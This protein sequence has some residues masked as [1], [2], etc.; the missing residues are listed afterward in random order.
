MRASLVTLALL[1]AAFPAH[2]Q[3]ARGD[4]AAVA[5]AARRA[6][7]RFE[8]VRR[9]S[10]PHHERRA[11]ECDTR[12][13]VQCYWYDS[14]DRPPTP[15]EH[16]RVTAARR[17]LLATLDSLALRSTRD[18]GIFG[19]RV[20]YHLEAG[21]T[22]RAIGIAGSE[23][24]GE[25]WWCMAL[26]GYVH[27][28]SGRFAAA[29]IAFDSAL[30]AMDAR[31]RCEWT[32]ASI[33]LPDGARRILHRLPC[34]ARAGEAERLLWL[35]DPL[36]SRPGNDFR[37]EYL[38]RR[39]LAELRARGIGVLDRWNEATEELLLRFGAHEWW[40]R[41]RPTVP[42]YTAAGG[43]TGHERVPS[44]AFLP[45]VDPDTATHV[46]RRYHW[47]LHERAPS[48][49]Y[50]PAYAA[51]W[52][53]IPVQLSGYRRG[54]S[55]MVVAVWSVAGDTLLDRGVARL[56]VATGPGR[57]TYVSAPVRAD[58]RVLTV[59][60]PVRSL[61]TMV[62][63]GLEVVDDARAAVGRARVVLAAPTAAPVALSDLMLLHAGTTTFVDGAEQS[64]ER[65]AARGIAGDTVTASQLAVHWEA[66]CGRVPDLLPLRF[67][68]IVARTDRSLL[69]RLN[70]RLGF[71]AEPGSIRVDW[72]ELPL[73]GERCAAR[74]MQ[75]DL[76]HLP[77]G[78]YEVAIQVRRGSAQ[79]A[80]VRRIRL[81][82]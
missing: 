23:C 3:A 40:T 73:A 41:E 57:P 10:L 79:A 5:R 20:L 53:A 4:S 13:G 18:G 70:A 28:V 19:R 64:L 43:I 69:A 37:S 59:T 8:S 55:L 9:A 56:A 62:I 51:R 1:V 50:A 44:F 2:A 77:D 29:G 81:R 21:D 16:A 61:D 32:D 67:S 14:T 38:A 45:R 63:G 80:S 30:G 48:A 34:A 42:A 49:R 15:R 76:G 17:R 6:Y 33:L 27:H 11:T 66:Y 24:R 39:T 60:V 82:R 54:D 22:A 25:A 7:E 31:G 58:E 72:Q 71:D 12:V 35:A 26:R 74:T 68:L 47:D 46:T 75:L 36:L 65:A 78:D 52:R